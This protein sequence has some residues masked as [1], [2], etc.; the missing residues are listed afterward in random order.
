MDTTLIAALFTLLGVGL[1]ILG[2]Y[3]VTRKTLNVE[4]KKLRNQILEIY[5]EELLKKR[6]E[7]YPKIYSCL[8]SFV[9]N[10]ENRN[11]SKESLHKLNAE[12]SQMDSDY[13]IFFEPLTIDACIKFRQ[14]LNKLTDLSEEGLSR[15]LSSPSEVES[16]LELLGDFEVQLKKELGVIGFEDFTPDGELRTK[17]GIYRELLNQSSVSGGGGKPKT[18]PPS[19]RT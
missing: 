18:L 15:A 7:I 12:F 9:K 5:S 3:F 10:I 16:L 8:S 14:T 11:V 6:V 19:G 2:S 13:A 4:A 1:S 17:P